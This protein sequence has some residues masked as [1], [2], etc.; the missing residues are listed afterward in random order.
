MNGSC[1][2]TCMIACTH[3]SDEKCGDFVIGLRVAVEQFRSNDQ[4]LSGSNTWRIDFFSSCQKCYNKLIFNFWLLS[5]VIA[6]WSEGY[7]TDTFCHCHSITDSTWQTPRPWEE[8]DLCHNS[9]ED[10]SHII[11]APEST[12]E[13]HVKTKNEAFDTRKSYLSQLLNFHINPFSHS[14]LRPLHQRMQSP[15]TQDIKSIRP[16]ARHWTLITRI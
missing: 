9:P 8:A 6:Y 2:M 11:W 10:N 5:L 12:P 7:K 14:H 1:N 15:N 3:K 4:T 16:K 13:M